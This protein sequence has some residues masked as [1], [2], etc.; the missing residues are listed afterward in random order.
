MNLQ[1]PCPLIYRNQI[2]GSRLIGSRSGQCELTYIS[3]GTLG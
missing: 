1:I 2:T 3:P